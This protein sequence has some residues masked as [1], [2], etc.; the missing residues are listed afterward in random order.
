MAR[1]RGAA[2]PSCKLAAIDADDLDDEAAEEPGPATHGMMDGDST[3]A[4]T[5]QPAS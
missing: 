3:A 1:P 4:G 5:S 2:G